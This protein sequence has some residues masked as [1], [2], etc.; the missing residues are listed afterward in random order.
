MVTAPTRPSLF[1]FDISTPVIERRLETPCPRTMQQHARVPRKASAPCSHLFPTYPA[2]ERHLEHP[3]YERTH[4]HQ[5]N[6]FATA[7]TNLN[8]SEIRRYLSQKYGSSSERGKKEIV[9]KNDD[10][11]R[12]CIDNVS[13][14]CIPALLVPSQVLPKWE[15]SRPT[16]K[17]KGGGGGVHPFGPAGLGKPH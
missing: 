6:P 3:V 7:K 4:A 2:F 1:L 14:I 17:K 8:P 5:R 11:D 13:S 12:S 15:C 10:L 9:Q 16:R